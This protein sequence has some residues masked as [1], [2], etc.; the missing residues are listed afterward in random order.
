[1]I[2]SIKS[3]IRSLVSDFANSSEEAFTYTT[4]S[5]FTIAQENIT[6]S[7]VT[8]NGSTSGVTYTYSSTTNKVT[9]TSA[10]TS[11]DI[12]LVSYT[13]NKYSSA[14]LDEYI[15]SALV[16]ISVYSYEDQDYELESGDVIAPTP[17]NQV[18]DEIA[19]IASI[20]IN[21]D[22]VQYRLPNCT[23]TYPRTMTK[24]VRIE[25]LIDRFNRGLG[26]SSTLN[27]DSFIN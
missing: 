20:L 2:T 5:I 21:P 13:Y 27:F 6:I 11:G 16:F 14:E 7:Q 8:V 26:I 18:C 3:K 1:M 17:S 15:R 19:L 10:L 25:K 22:Y 23:V 12:I 24:E 4:S 9:I